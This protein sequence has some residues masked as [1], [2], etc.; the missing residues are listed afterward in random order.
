MTDERNNAT[1]V[2]FAETSLLGLP[3]RVQNSWS[4]ASL[5]IPHHSMSCM[6]GVLNPRQQSSSML[7][8]GYTEVWD[9][10][11]GVARISGK[12]LVTSPILLRKINTPPSLL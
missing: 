7:Q 3:V 9:N 10:R 8:Q 1:Q 4:A 12:S 11:N 2:Q 6:T 5:K